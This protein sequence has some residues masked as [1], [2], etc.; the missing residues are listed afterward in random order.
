MGRVPL[1]SFLALVMWVSGCGGDGDG[2]VMSG[3]ERLEIV[4]R[5]TAMHDSLRTAWIEGDAE[6]QGRYH[7]AEGVITYDRRR[8]TGEAFHGWA[9]RTGKNGPKQQVGTL[10]NLQ[11]DVRSRETAASVFEYDYAFLDSL[12][13]PRTEMVALMT[14]AWVNTDAGWRVLHLHESTFEAEQVS[15][16]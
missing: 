2:D 16:E 8:F 11:I 9:A 13:A 5:I 3:T 7:L 1:A 12:G 15:A 14:L 6:A 10:K 4:E